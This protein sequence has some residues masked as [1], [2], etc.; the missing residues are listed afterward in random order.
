MVLGYAW[1]SFG[2]ESYSSQAAALNGVLAQDADSRC[3]TECE[4]RVAI[5]CPTSCLVS[6][7]ETSA[8]TSLFV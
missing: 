3:E 6:Q 2:T 8:P 4:F 7:T 1:K 5:L